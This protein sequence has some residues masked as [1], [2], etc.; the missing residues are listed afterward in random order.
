M[1]SVIG[2]I[3]RR[4]R[5]YLEGKSE[6]KRRTERDKRTYTRRE[7]ERKIVMKFH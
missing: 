4:T 3:D 7:R 2:H 5:I 6:I 1:D